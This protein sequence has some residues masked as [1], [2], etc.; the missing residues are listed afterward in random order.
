ML[1]CDLLT[2]E[3]A[4]EIIE[5]R[6]RVFAITSPATVAAALAARGLELPNLAIAAGFTALDAEPIPAL[7]LGEAGRLTAGPAVRD[8]APDTFGLLAR[9]LVGVAASPAQLDARGAANLS[10][11]GPLGAPKVALPGSQGLPDNGASPSRVWYLY[12]A[13]SPRTLVERVDVVSGPP[14]PPGAIRRLLTPAGC[15]ELTPDGWSARWLTPEGPELVAGTPGFGIVLSGEEAV[16]REPD[17]RLL[18]AVRAADPHDVRAI[19]F[20]QGDEAG[21]RSALAAERERERGGGR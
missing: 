6:I 4:R 15:F 1:T 5:A 16:I 7:T 2:C 13:H 17:A 3:L 14:P 10:G 20:S 19:E 9:G 18:A 8:W 12:G 21:R 11:I